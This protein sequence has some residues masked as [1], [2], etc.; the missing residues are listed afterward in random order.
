MAI[1]VG[2]LRYQ[3]RRPS[4]APLL[5]RLRELASVRVRFGYR[6]LTVLLKREGWPVNAKRIYRLY[7]EDGLVVR[8]RRRTKAAQRQRRPLAAAQQPNERWSMDFVHDR[9]VDGR[10]FRILTVIDQFTREC[11]QVWAEGSLTGEK[12]ARQ[13]EPIVAVRGAPGSITVDNGSEFASRALDHWAYRHRVHLQFI[14]PGK[15]VENGFIESFNG[16]L[17]DECLNAHMFL[18]LAEVRA[19]LADWQQD[20]N[21]NRPHSA[22]GDRAPAEFAA[23]WSPPAAG[24]M[25]TS[26][27]LLEGLN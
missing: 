9:L 26:R 15:P 5:L 21:R 27:P 4:Q 10:S 13:L 20:Y 24:S 11:L 1:A 12:V 16:R 14:R 2:T 6:R 18:S 8:T 22:L 7:K 17:R 23:D 25:G 3:S 19:K